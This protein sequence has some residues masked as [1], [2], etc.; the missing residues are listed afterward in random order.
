MIKPED[1]TAKVTGINQ[2]NDKV[3]VLFFECDRDFKYQAGQFVNLKFEDPFGE[4][5]EIQ[6]AYSIASVSN[7]KVFELCVE[8]IEGGRGSTYIDSLQV[9]DE[10]KIKAP[11]G[12]CCIKE[13]NKNDLVMVGTGTGIAPIK[14]ILEELLAKNDERR[15]D[16]FFGVRHESDLFYMDELAVLESRLAN[17]NLH[18]TLSQPQS[19]DWSGLSGRVTTHLEE[20]DFSNMPD[21]Y[22]CGGMAMIKDVM[23]LAQGKGIERKK[24]HVEI[25]DV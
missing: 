12:F 2:V 13:D 6:R 21:V 4:Q 11:F 25:F 17:M 24:I 3:K 9:D 7:G 19:P 1:F 10:V 18:V 14:A 23:K 8:I 16:V 15:I 22:I 20:F 5:G